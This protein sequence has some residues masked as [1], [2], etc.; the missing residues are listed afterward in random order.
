MKFLKESKSNKIFCFVLGAGG[1]VFFCGG[2][3]G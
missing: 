2:D 3:G 1:G